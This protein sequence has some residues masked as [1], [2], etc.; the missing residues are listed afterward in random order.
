MIRDIDFQVPGPEQVEKLIELCR[1]EGWTVDP[2]RDVTHYEKGVPFHFGDEFP[3]Y[4][5]EE[6]HSTV[7]AHKADFDY[8]ELEAVH[9]RADELAAQVGGDV[10]GGGCA[11]NE[12]E[13]P[14]LVTEDVIPW[15]WDAEPIKAYIVKQVGYEAPGMADQAMEIRALLVAAGWTPPPLVED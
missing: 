12:D 13:G 11:F 1:A 9:A 5:P 2:E 6:T 8:D 15:I 14:K 10:T 7:V 3:P 4:I